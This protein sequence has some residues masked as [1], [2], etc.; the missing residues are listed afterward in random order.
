MMKKYLCLLLFG[1]LPI[2]SLSAIVRAQDIADVSP[3]QK[4]Q[5]ERI[6]HDYLTRAETRDELVKA[7]L[8][9][10]L[11]VYWDSG[12]RM[13]SED[14]N[15]QLQIG[16]RVLNDWGWFD[17]ESDVRNA[18]GDQVDGVE[19]RSSRLYMSGT[20][21]KNIGFKVQYD[22]AAGGR[23]S[24]NA[25]YME[26][27]NL[28]YL[29]N[30]RV[31]HI[32]EPFSM[33]VLTANKFTTFMERGLS[34]VFAQ[35]WNTGIMA[36]NHFM[37][38][39]MTYAAGVFRNSDAFGDSEGGRSTEGGYSYTA[40]I[41]GLP[42]YEDGG[43]KLLHT[44]VSVS[45]Q[46][47]FDNDFRFA[48]RPEMNMADTFVDTGSFIDAGNVGEWA[49]Y[50]NP[51]IALVWGAFSFQTEY[52]FANIDLDDNTAGSDPD[53]SGW[54]A[55]GSYFLTGEH[56]KYGMKRGV[57]GRIKPYQNFDWNGGWGAIE[58]KARYSELDLN[59]E[60]IN[61]GRL[62]DLT[63]GVTWYLNPNTKVMFDYVHAD[64]DRR[65]IALD[66]G[67]ADLFGMRFQVDF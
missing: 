4:E 20:I 60:G 65:A 44:G 46:N 35:I 40:R 3:A 28:P 14:G 39:R 6:I 49:T 47:A 53:F 10:S 31:G 11:N 55:Y 18:I 8:I 34:I 9:S 57:F 29:G 7:G 2:V 64:V 13:E 21:Y 52:T 1:L 24:F 22:F 48:A 51:E 12:L 43:K 37:D 19:F 26:L 15:L 58:L 32:K 54:Y 25:V 30:I 38:K 23:P 63:L 27:K 41:T 50:V 5:F 33:E 45:A 16:G 17:E 67:E 59:D 61:G 36:H 42:F 56:R 66:D 62:N